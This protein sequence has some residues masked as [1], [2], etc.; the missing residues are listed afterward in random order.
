MFS[1]WFLKFL[2]SVRMLKQRPVEP[3]QVFSR[4]LRQHCREFREPRRLTDYCQICADFD[5]SVLPQLKK[6]Q[7]ATRQELEAQSALYFQAWDIHAQTQEYDNK[8]ALLS[9]DFLHFI[10]RHDR[11]NP[12]RHH[13]GT[14]F[15]CG[16][17][18][19]PRAA[20]GDLLSLREVEIQRLMDL[21]AMDK[22]VSSYNFHRASNDHQKPCIDSL[23]AS[24]EFNRL[25]MISDWAELLTLPLQHKQT[26]EAFY[27]AARKELSVFGAV[28]AEHMVGSTVA[29]PKVIHTSILFLSDILDHTATRTWQ[30]VEK[31][32]GCRRSSTAVQGVDLISDCAGHFR[33]YE[34]LHVGLIHLVQKYDAEVC[35]H[36]GVEKHLKHQCDRLFGWFRTGIKRIVEDGATITDIIPLQRALQTYF[37]AARARDVTSPLVKVLIDND[38]ACPEK[39]CK[40][41]IPNFKISRTY[42]ISGR[43]SEYAYLGSSLRNH[44]Y[45]S[46]PVNVPIYVEA[47]QEVAGPG[48]WRRGYYGKG[49][50]AWN[51]KPVPLKADEETVLTK[52]MDAQSS[53]LPNHRDRFHGH[54]GATFQEAFNK[55]RRRQARR[56][57]RRAVNAAA[58]G[59]TSSSSSTSST[60]SDSAE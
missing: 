44:T 13:R 43:P 47:V 36:F 46:K 32:L 29:C 42:C 17:Q 57:R 7:T 35:L 48:T 21:R 59:A 31:A 8:P 27:G 4:I 3:C 20:A 12:C 9:G 19:A 24:P 26:G 22:L 15:P 56:K 58:Q 41:V 37:N 60:S 34:A 11:A 14:P 33:S 38:S 23:L 6:L 49:A 50:S 52:R 5:D 51:T 30:L 25:T 40:L 45:S 1:V 28:I 39:V 55:L 53:L 10:D 54:S 2:R 18:S 16:S